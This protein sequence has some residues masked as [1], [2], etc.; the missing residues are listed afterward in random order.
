MREFPLVSLLIPCYN[1]EKY[2]DDNLSSLVEQD[3]ENMEL[4][5]CDDCSP[6][7]SYAKIRGWEERLRSRFSRVE[8]LRNEA[9]CGVTK[10]INRML[11]LA[12]GD[13]IKILASDDAM[14]PDA[15]SA[16]VACMRETHADVLIVGGFKI[17]EDRHFPHFGSGEPVYP[18]APDLS[19]E[20]L[21]VRTALNNE[22][23]APGAFVSREV[24]RR[25][26]TYDESIPVEDFEFWLRLTKDGKVRFSYLDKPLI[27]YRVSAGSI[28]SQTG[29]AGLERRRRMFHRAEMDTLRKYAP[30][31]PRAVYAEAVLRRILD[32][33]YLAVNAGLSAWDRELRREWAS[34]SEWNALPWKSRVR[35]WERGI[36]IDIKGRRKD[37]E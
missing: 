9:N 35:Y 19:G 18:A 28:T 4:L 8:L 14:M 10:N 29:N 36:K 3:Y 1:H 12:E 20:G 5:I 37:S 16:A 22:I 11:A 6:D 32:E 17:P 31:L 26:G 13:I 23:F 21:F 27:C 24:F 34:F 15:V 7:G 30:D 33:R 25:Y 2:L